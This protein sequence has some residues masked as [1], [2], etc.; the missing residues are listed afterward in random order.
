[1]TTLWNRVTGLFR[2]KPISYTEAKEGRDAQ[3]EVDR[4]RAAAQHQFHDRTVRN[5]GWFM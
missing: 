4:A 3:A 1:M 2:R 5:S